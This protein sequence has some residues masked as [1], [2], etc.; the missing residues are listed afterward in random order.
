MVVG[1]GRVGV[2]VKRFTVHDLRKTVGGEK[3]H[4]LNPQEKLYTGFS[5]VNVASWLCPSFPHVRF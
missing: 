5:L 3:K 4:T 2:E 1:Q